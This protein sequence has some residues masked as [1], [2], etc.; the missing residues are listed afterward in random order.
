MKRIAAAIMLSFAMLCADE[1]TTKD[2]VLESVYMVLHVVDWAQTRHIADNPDLFY[3]NNPLIG[4]NPSRRRVDMIFLVGAILHPIV[5]YNM[6]KGWRD[7]WFGVSIGLE[8]A[9]VSNN[10]KIGVRM[11]F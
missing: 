4:R 6:P 5:S 7:V 8:L 9:C 1:W 3:E 10:F 2:T 11:R